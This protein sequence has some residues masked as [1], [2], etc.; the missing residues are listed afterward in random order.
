MLRLKASVA[1]LEN[2]YWMSREINME[3]QQ[4]QKDSH[5]FDRSREGFNYAVYVLW[6]T[7]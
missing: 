5:D 6:A 1:V 7:M 2:A 4:L 3:R